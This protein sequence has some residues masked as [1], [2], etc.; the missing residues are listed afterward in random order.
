[1]KSEKFGVAL[2]VVLVL[3]G[4]T[5]LFWIP[6]SPPAIASAVSSISPE[7]ITRS[8]GPLPETVVENYM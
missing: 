3:G 6:R 4:A 1:M 2:I 7:D 8:V 5:T